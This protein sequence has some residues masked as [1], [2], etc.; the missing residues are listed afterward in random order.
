MDFIKLLIRFIP[1]YKE[2]IIAY[3]SL[4]FLSS[5]CSVFSFIA[6]IPLIQI[7]FNL[8]DNTF[9][10]IDTTEVHTFSEI[11]DAA[12][13]N[14]MFYLQEQISVYGES[15]VLLM[16]G[17][18]VILTS[19]LFNIISYLAYWVRIPIRTGI[20]RDLR[21]DA[22]DKIINMPIHTFSKENRGDF[23]S[24]MTN[25]VE[26]TE[27]GIGTTLDMFIKDPI[28]IIVYII[29]M[30][31][32]SSQLTLYAISMIVVV[33][34]FVLFLGQVMQKI[35]YEAQQNKG[36][37]LSVFEQTLGVLPIIK[38][39]NAQHVFI[40]K[41]TKL[42]L[43]TQKIF[44]KQN[45]F[46]SLA[47]PSTDFLITVIIVIMLCL[48]GYL[49]LSGAS[50]LNP[51]VFIGFLGVL[52][53]IIP[54]I[55][56][57]MKCTFGIRKAMASVVRLN[58]ILNIANESIQASNKTIKFSED[59]P[60]FEIKNLTLRYENETILKDV[61]LKIN[62]GKKIAVLGATGSGKSTLLSLLT[63]LNEEYEGSI[64]I[65][66]ENIK[67]YSY[68]TTRDYIAYVPQSPMLLNDTIRNNIT[69]NNN[70]TDIDVIEATKK[71]YIHD[72]IMTLPDKYETIVGDRGCNLSG[73][74]QQCIS[75]ARAII[76]NSP[77]LIIDEGTA[78]LDPKLEANIMSSLINNK[79]EKTMIIVSHKISTVLNADFVY[80]LNEGRIIDS[81][82]PME[83][84]HK[85]G[86]FKSMAE[87]QNVKL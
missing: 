6:I 49:I 31:G 58:K 36:K 2:R 37:I 13:N 81:G 80:I 53:S 8:S 70:Y 4:N 73:G 28:Q 75:L 61:S 35:S 30:I 5:I 56:D 46:Y 17:A 68:N 72:Y 39:F 62:K 71:A 23:V 14:I 42:N 11:L 33:C 9:S 84:Y 48:G 45:R 34:L 29:T 50:T 18:F 65:S 76:K 44:N 22:Y 67:T 20:S 63:R 32:I 19:F 26:E 69:L 55:R 85:E 79:G 66:G 21:R 7:L 10:Y 1:Q 38:S 40:N 16:I 54:P 59:F 83:L 78:S 60:V 47:W 64:L 87:L 27:Y 57:M 52:Y 24:R 12:K 41:F 25:D 3:V 82:T 77:I 51:A 43:Q 74:Q 86:Y 15:K